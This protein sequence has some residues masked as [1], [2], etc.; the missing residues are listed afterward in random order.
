MCVGSVGLKGFLRAAVVAV[1][2][3]LAEPRQ[4]SAEPARFHR[5]DLEVPRLLEPD[6]PALS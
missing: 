1:T 6:T 2:E 5:E 3:A 4:H